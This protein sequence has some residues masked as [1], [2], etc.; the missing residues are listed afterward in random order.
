MGNFKITCPHE[1]SF[2]NE[3]Q[4]FVLIFQNRLVAIRAV[5][6]GLYVQYTETCTVLVTYY[7]RFHLR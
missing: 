2:N 4:Y 5:S 3:K 7:F 1:N 6:G